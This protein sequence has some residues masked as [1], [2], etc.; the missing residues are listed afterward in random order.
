[1]VRVVDYFVMYSKAPTVWTLQ[2]TEKKWIS[3]Q[4]VSEFLD[5]CNKGW[6]RWTDWPKKDAGICRR[7]VRSSSSGS[8]TCRWS[9]STSMEG[10][11]SC[12]SEM[13]TT[14][15]SRCTQIFSTCS[16]GSST[17]WCPHSTW[18]GLPRETRS[19]LPRSVCLFV[20]SSHSTNQPTCSVAVH[21]RPADGSAHPY[22]RFGGE[23]YPGRGCGRQIGFCGMPHWFWFCTSFRQ[24]PFDGVFFLMIK[25]VIV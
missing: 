24:L 7:R 25:F 8:S 9:S 10:S 1:M 15:H 14:V 6:F 23:A 16:T 22:G 13:T 5:K 20:T 3:Y 21:D 18:R 11:R 2:E 4:L 17:A 12:S 19:R